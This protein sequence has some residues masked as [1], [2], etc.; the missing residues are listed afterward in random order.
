MEL[1]ENRLARGVN[2]DALAVFLQD[3]CREQSVHA[4]YEEAQRRRVP[5]AP[6][7]TMGDL[8]ASPHLKARGFFA[9]IAHPVGGA[10]T[11]PGAPYRL[12]ATPWALRRPAPC[13]GQHT[14]EVLAEIGLD[15]R[16]LAAEGIV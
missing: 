14:V 16:R 15:A 11:M 3:W 9:T 8:L 6:V 5:F 7:S 13:L 1:F 2:F 12:S 4:L 10:V